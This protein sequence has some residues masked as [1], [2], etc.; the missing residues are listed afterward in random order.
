LYII[1]GASSRN[2]AMAGIT[3]ADQITGD[4]NPSTI[5]KGFARSWI[6]ILQ[7]SPETET[8]VRIT[9]AVAY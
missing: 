6:L 3:L 8:T 5:L 4:P 7:C 2:G 9:S 1:T